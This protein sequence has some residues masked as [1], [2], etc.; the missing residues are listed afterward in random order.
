MKAKLL[1]LGALLCAGVNVFAHAI[2][3]ETS[4]KGTKGKQQNVQIYFGEYAENERD[5]TAKWF[6]NL[7]DIQLYLIAPDGTKQ[8]LDTHAET[9]HMAAA[10]TPAKE[11]TY[12]LAVSHTVADIYAESKIEYY[13]TAAVFVNSKETKALQA[14]TALAV[15]PDVAAASVGKPVALNVWYNQSGVDNAKVVISS[16]GGW[17]KTVHSNAKGA[18][19]FVPDVKGLYQVE[20]IRVDKTPGT[21]N[22][23]AYKSVTHLVTY[24]VNAQ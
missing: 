4:S 12:T 17:Q 23:K 6:S 19:S 3:I 10:F 18:A 15:Q 20:A 8:K 24:C 14:A 22:G 2:W 11:G 1:L 5:S 13:T 7:R 9:N 21:H 16:P